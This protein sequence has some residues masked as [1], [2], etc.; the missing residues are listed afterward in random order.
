MNCPE[1][2][3]EMEDDGINYYFCPACSYERAYANSLFTNSQFWPI[4]DKSELFMV[5]HKFQS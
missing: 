1:C 4:H 3:T 2:G 5:R